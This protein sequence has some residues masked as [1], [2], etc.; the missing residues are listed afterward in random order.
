VLKRPGSVFGFEHVTGDWQQVIAHP[1]VE[2]VNIAAPNG[3]HLEMNRAAARAGKHI[4]CE[5]P[6]GRFPE[7]TIQS[8]LAAREPAWLTFVGYNYRWAPVVQYARVLI[9]RGMLGT[10]THYHDA[11]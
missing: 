4:L 11:S 3:M 1:E 2:V 6:V 5:K 7:D 8:Y 9:E 10:L